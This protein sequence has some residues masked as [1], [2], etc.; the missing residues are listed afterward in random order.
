MHIKYAIAYRCLAPSCAKAM[1]THMGF[2]ATLSTASP[3]SRAARFVNPRRPYSLVPVYSGRTT[4]RGRT[5]RGAR[6]GGAASV[7]HRTRRGETRRAEAGVRRRSGPVGVV[8]T[9]AR[10][11]GR[12]GPGRSPSG[13]PRPGAIGRRDLRLARM[14]LCAPVRWR[15]RDCA[16]VTGRLRITAQRPPGAAGGRRPR[17]VPSDP[18]PGRG[19]AARGR[20]GR[21]ALGSCSPGPSAHPRMLSGPMPSQR[22]ASGPP[23]GKLI[24]CRQRVAALQCKCSAQFFITALR[25]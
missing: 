2:H 9:P 24:L 3:V 20:P 19:R 25:E 5:G 10:R 16:R 13:R 14:E 6:S 1:I 22:W 21:L 12:P 18:A 8:F 7:P 23:F 4:G 15:G 17:R 11:P